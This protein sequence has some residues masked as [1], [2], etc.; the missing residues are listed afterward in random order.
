MTAWYRDV[1]V[2]L[3]LI[4]GVVLSASPAAI[5][6][7]PSGLLTDHDS[8]GE[9][10]IF[11]IGDSNSADNGPNGPLPRTSW[12]GWTQRDGLLPRIQA[13]LDDEVEASEKVVWKNGAI[14]GWSC[15]GTTPSGKNNGLAWM[16]AALWNHADAVIVSAGT[17]DLQ[18]FNA[19]P[20]AVV[21]CYQ[22]MQASAAEAHMAF[23]V[24]TTPPVYPP[25]PDAAASNHVIGELNALIRATFDPRIVIDFDS[26][27]TADMF[28]PIGNGRHVNDDGQ[29]LR[30][31]RVAERLTAAQL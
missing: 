11:V 21:D 25:Y 28:P 27:F 22:Q 1:E 14:S 26:G 9:Y 7:M 31:R 4:A 29:K 3:S 8:D 19:T 18:V 6:G 23:F 12:V 30:A 2:L 13:L 17:N 10:R 16:F 24:A 15:V 5:G 20:R